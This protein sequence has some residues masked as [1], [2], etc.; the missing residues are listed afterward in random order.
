MWDKKACEKIIWYFFKSIFFVSLNSLPISA[1][2]FRKVSSDSPCISFL[3]VRYDTL[4]IVYCT[5]LYC[6]VLYCTVLNCTVLNCT[7]LYCTKLYCTVLYL[8]VLYCTVSYCTLLY[9]TLLYCTVLCCTVLYRT[10]LYCTA[11][12]CI[13]HF[14]RTIYAVKYHPTIMTNICEHVRLTIVPSWLLVMMSPP[15]QQ[16]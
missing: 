16:Q 11:L 7:V 10:V 8:T 14:R 4:K 15:A 13:I 5:V 1:L 12:H 3:L 9:C 6:T 2:L